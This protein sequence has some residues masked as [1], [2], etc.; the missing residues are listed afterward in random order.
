MV[1]FDI[2]ISRQFVWIFQEAKIATCS[3]TDKHNEDLLVNSISRAQ[4]QFERN[5]RLIERNSKLSE[6][7][8]TRQTYVYTL[9]TLSFTLSDICRYNVPNDCLLWDIRVALNAIVHGTEFV[10]PAIPFFGR[11]EMTGYCNAYVHTNPRVP[12]MQNTKCDN[13]K[14][15]QESVPKSMSAT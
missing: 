6:Q 12:K 11:W 15:K 7:F 8:E 9:F 5:L 2:K 3:Y 4:T 14:I 10:R 1:A 13:E